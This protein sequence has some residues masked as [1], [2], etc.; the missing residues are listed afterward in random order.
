MSMQ[1]ERWWRCRAMNREQ[2]IREFLEKKR[3]TVKTFRCPTLGMQMEVDVCNA[4]RKTNPLFSRFSFLECVSCQ[5]WESFQAS[6]QPEVAIESEQENQ[7]DDIPELILPTTQVQSNAPYGYRMSRIYDA[8]EIDMEEFCVLYEIV[9]QHNV[10]GL[11]F[12]EI[13]DML[14]DLKI[15]TRKRKKFNRQIVRNIWIRQTKFTIALAHVS[16]NNRSSYTRDKPIRIRLGSSGV[17]R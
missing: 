16:R 8:Y 17:K 12:T 3:Q 7:D 14:N 5:K 6:T 2:Q 10:R 4:R 9:F 15:R 11:K 13:A 1:T